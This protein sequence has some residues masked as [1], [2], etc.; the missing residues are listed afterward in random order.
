MHVHVHGKYKHVCL[1]CAAIHVVCMCFT[2]TITMSTLKRIQKLLSIPKD[3]SPS[4]GSAQLVAL[5][6]I[7]IVLGNMLLILSEQMV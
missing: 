2:C 4:L 6:S 5:I 7:A 3:P 1:M